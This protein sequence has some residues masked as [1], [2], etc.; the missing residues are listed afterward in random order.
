MVGALAPLAPASAQSGARW[1]VRRVGGDEATI[2]SAAVSNL[3][4]VDADTVVLARADNYPDALAGAPLAGLLGAPILLTEQDELPHHVFTELDRLRPELVILLGGTAALSTSIED[5]LRDDLSL[6]NTLRLGGATRFDTAALIADEI[7]RRGGRTDRAFLVRGEHPEPVRAWPDAVAVSTLAARSGTPILLAANDYV[8]SPTFNALEAHGINDVIVIGGPAA[9]SHES[10]GTV[11]D[12][13]YNVSRIAGDS[14]F[15][16]SLEVADR[17]LLE[18]ADPRNVWLVTGGNYADALV[19][20]PAAARDNAIVLMIDGAHWE[21]SAAQSFLFD[22]VDAVDQVT[23]IGSPDSIPPS[24]DRDIVVARTGT[25]AAPDT[26]GGVRIEAGRNIQSVVDA[27]PPGTHFV[28]GSG[29]HRMQS[30]RPRTGDRFTGE[31]GAVLNGAM[32]YDHADFT[33]MADGRWEAPAP[34]EDP[35]PLD[36][37][38]EVE[39]GHEREA[40]PNELWGGHR[41]LDHANA[42]DMV[43]APG[44]WF[45]D[46]AGDRI[47]M[48]DNPR[49]YG[50]IE[51]SV[52]PVA[53]DAVTG[54]SVADVIIENVT[55]TRYANNPTR[56]AIE[57]SAGRHWTVRNVEVIENHA[58][59]M[60]VGPGM[61]VRDSRFIRNGQ[62]G[63]GGSDVDFLDGYKSPVVISNN[64]VAHNGELRFVWQWEAGSIKFGETIGLEITNNWVHNHRGP[65]PWIDVDCQDTL[66]EGNLVEFN[67]ENGIMHEISRN[68]VIRNNI[69]RNNGVTAVGDLGSGLWISNSQD[70]LA[71]GNTI[72]GNRLPIN[73]QSSTV[74]HGKDGERIVSNLLVRDNDIRI[75]YL[76]P[77]LRVTSDDEHLYQ[78]GNNRF[79]SNTYRLRQGWDR[80]FFWGQFYTVDT[81]QDDLGHDLDGEFIPLTA[82]ASYPENGFALNAIGTS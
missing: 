77:G 26:S 61:E 54:Q 23:V 58:I 12:A 7:A 67:L 82:P 68:G 33:Q 63:I 50:T 8:P 70:V 60:K 1:D 28:L 14:R 30:I 19:A 40:Y 36:P 31:T 21:N 32:P 38:W 11:G 2:L 46:Y 76:A 27:N 44:E 29:V 78:E 37:K 65:G 64:E 18:G 59:G 47:V 57:A 20:S 3:T 80:N 5:Q 55:I 41:R 71:E 42:L 10:A 79:E 35:E 48:F 17:A 75:D 53:F 72:E 74:D 43:D 56:G 51:L 69:V 22:R 62:M 66:I 52:N 73:A 45:Y 24:V 25:P 34:A 13:G 49:S 6:F 4:T 15:A 81:W 39:P 16:T 9:L